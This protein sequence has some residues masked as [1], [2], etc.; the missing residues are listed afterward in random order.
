[1]QHCLVSELSSKVAW[2]I[3]RGVLLWSCMLPPDDSV[4][5]ELGPPGH[6]NGF[7]AISA[8]GSIQQ[9]TPLPRSLGLGTSPFGEKQAISLGRPQAIP[10]EW[11]FVGAD[12]CI[13]VEQ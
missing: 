6:I 11:Y 8:F 7:A 12:L 13:S 9:A 10:H 2:E 5:C 1:M 4:G 3:L